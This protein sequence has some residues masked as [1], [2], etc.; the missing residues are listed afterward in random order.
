MAWSYQVAEVVHNRE[1]VEERM[2]FVV[3][4]FAG[5]HVGFVGYNLD[6]LVVFRILVELVVAVVP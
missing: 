5:N 3:A 6:S 4:E 2:I 1:E